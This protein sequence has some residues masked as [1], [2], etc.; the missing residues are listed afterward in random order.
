VREV[1]A[2]HVVRLGQLRALR[3]R[4]GV[5]PAVHRVV[6]LHRLLR[7]PRADVRR[8]RA[9]DVALQQRQHGLDPPVPLPRPRTVVRVDLRR[10]D[11]DRVEV[12]GARRVA[13]RSG[14]VLTHDE[15]RFRAPRTV[16]VRRERGSAEV[17]PHSAHLGGEREARERVHRSHVVSV[18]NRSAEA[19]ETIVELVR[20]DLFSWWWWC[21]CGGE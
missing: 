9:L 14:A 15:G 4:E 16:A 19:D 11:V 12:L 17:L 5:G 8:L 7:V 6:H 1:L 3:H 21:A 13:Q 18:V 20:H 2:P 10:F